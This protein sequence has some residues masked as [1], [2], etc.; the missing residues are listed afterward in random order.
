MDKK[1][2]IAQLRDAIRCHN[3]RYYNLDN[4]LIT[5]KEY[6]ELYA[7]LKKLEQENP[8][9]DDPSSPT[10]KVGGQAA[11]NIFMPVAHGA[12]MMSLDN[13]Y[14]E[15][16]IID[17]HERCCKILGVNDFEMAVETKIDGLSCSLT[18]IDSKLMRAATRGDGATGEDITVNVMT[19]PAIPHELK[20]FVN[21]IAEIRGEVFMDKAD[22]A[23]L[24]EKQAAQKL[25]VFAN[26]RNAAAG[27]LR[28][29]NP[30]ITAQRKLKFYVHSIGINNFGAQ[31][32]TGFLDKCE[33]FG[34]PVPHIRKTFRDIQSVIQFYNDFKNDLHNLPYDADG[35]VV[36]VNSLELQKKLGVTAKSPRWAMAFKYPAQQAE[37]IVKKI[38]FSV[39]RTGVITPVAELEPVACAGVIISSATLHNFDEIAR[40]G[41]REGDR[42]LIERAG[43]VIPKV[44][45]VISQNHAAK[46]VAP[47]THCPVCESEVFK[48]PDT[49]AYRCINPNCPAQIKAHIEHFASR[50]AMD[51]D[52]LGESAIEQLVDNGQIK[53][54]SDIYS[55][56][57]FDLMALDLFADKKADNLLNAIDRSKKRPLAKFIFS[58]GINHVGSKTAEILAANFL[59]VENLQN[60]SFEEVQKVNEIGPIIAQSIVE[61][62][63]SHEVKEELEKLK[64]YGL[65]F[66]APKPKESAL[67]EGKTFVFTG[68]LPTMTRAQAELLAKDNGAKVSSSVSAKTYAVVAGADAGS[69]LEKA[70]KLGVKILTEEEFL[71]MIGH[72]SGIADS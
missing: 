56:T 35:L 11:L 48:D 13:S 71:Q 52:G 41:V 68:E 27:S 12:P 31:T 21:G 65:Q 2:E 38:I 15:Q 23:A 54:I 62:F 20:D 51:I 46:A 10:K 53:K 25:P 57:L 30:Q 42:V 18:Y 26:T 36:K 66:E 59:T 50:A 24:N 70:Q 33:Q 16:D 47:P 17:W 1:Q 72:N 43:E 67:L 45:K 58:L 69:K 64:H 9:F 55:L 49:V 37:T 29:K 7:R 6:D 32:F 14:N 5:D 4:P 19:I 28:Q 3:N 44:I 61:F 63:A 34:L 40:L 60:A 8:Q 39:G 22:L